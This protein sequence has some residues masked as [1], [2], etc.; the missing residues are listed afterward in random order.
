MSFQNDYK[1]LRECS[2]ET[3]AIQ[4]FPYSSLFPQNQLSREIP[5]LVGARHSCNSVRKRGR[6]GIG[7]GLFSSRSL[8]KTSR[9]GKVGKF[10][11]LRYYRPPQYIADSHGKIELEGRRWSPLRCISVALEGHTFHYNMHGS[12]SLSK[13]GNKW[14]FRTS[15]LVARD[16]D[17]GGATDSPGRV[18]NYQVDSP[19]L[20]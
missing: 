20:L 9:P 6:F 1:L 17:R 14:R 13:C 11:L 16:Y 7:A 12:R 2:C 5:P 4:T 15:S 8:C 3:Q 18:F 19:F 10:S